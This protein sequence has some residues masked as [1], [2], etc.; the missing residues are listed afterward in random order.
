MKKLIIL[1]VVV[2]SFLIGVSVGKK[3]VNKTKSQIVEFYDNMVGD[4]IE[5]Y[6]K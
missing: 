4:A 3:G 1:V 2:V 5:V 6:S